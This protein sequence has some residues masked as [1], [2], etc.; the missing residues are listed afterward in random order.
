[1]KK[2]YIKLIKL[3]Q[4]CIPVGYL[5][6]MLLLSLIVYTLDKSC[7]AILVMRNITN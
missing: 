2:E 1:M 6:L 4:K 5:N 3:L 7:N